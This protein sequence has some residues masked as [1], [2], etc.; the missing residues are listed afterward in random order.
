MLLLQITARIADAGEGPLNVRDQ[1]AAAAGRPFLVHKWKVII[2][3]SCAVDMSRMYA[4]LKPLGASHDV[5]AYQLNGPLPGS[6]W[7]RDVVLPSRCP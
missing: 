7:P 3:M 5:R 1:G 2:R 6:S 4:S